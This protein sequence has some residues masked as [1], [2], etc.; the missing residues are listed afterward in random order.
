MKTPINA[1]SPPQI[2]ETAY[3]E[4][5]SR[6]NASLE[7]KV[8]PMEVVSPDISSCWRKNTSSLEALELANLLRALR[9]VAGHLGD[10]VGHI[11][12]AGMS[13]A[14]KHAI[15]IEPEMVMGRYPVPA[16]KVDLLVGLLVHEAMHRMEWSDHVWKKLEPAME[17][18]TPRAKVIFQK[19]VRT[20]ESIFMDLRS[21]YTVFGLYTRI[22][23]DKATCLD[24]SRFAADCPCVDT[25]MTMWRE[26][27]FDPCR[28]PDIKPDMLPE[29][30]S[31]FGELTK[32]T[33][34]LKAISQGAAGVTRRCE[35]R[36]G[37]YLD[38]WKKIESRIA[39]WKIIDK[40]LYWFSYLKSAGDEKKRTAG[41]NSGKNKKLPPVLAR[42]IET[43][44][45][46]DAVDMTPLIRSVAGYENE[47]VAPMSRWDFQSASHPVVDR[48]MIGRLRAVFSHY[49]ER[50]SLMSRGLASGRIDQRRLY[51][52]GVDGRCF[53][54]I[55]K[56]PNLDWSVGLL[57]DASGSMRGN[58]WQMVE[59]TIATIHKALSGYRNR[60]SAWA[61]F[62]VSGICM[63]SRLITK[64]QLF[65]VPPA[66]QTA[67]GQAII[68]SA[69]MM[70]ENVKHTLLIHITDGESNFGCDV[71]YGLEYCRQ[72]KIQL[73][74]LGCGYKDR[75][76]MEHQYGRS[77][78]FIDYFEQLPK[79][80]ETL[81]KWAF[82]YGGI[83]SFQAPSILTDSA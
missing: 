31:P 38:T 82:L 8:S 20:G 39:D 52:A 16:Q 27:A 72:R 71:S 56:I 7:I 75:P 48:K 62:E 19:L 83:R 25:L 53:T 78:Q 21:E 70:P 60:L 22:V 79:A 15:L 57:V 1:I 29:Q 32:M 67:S 13:T 6:E 64:N 59:N 69:S 50:N 73:I 46:G 66:G 34:D 4:C 43:C 12:Y 2:R 44:L 54:S 3:A 49:A 68:A 28:M 24:Q 42:D 77:I 11:E 51:R 74:T 18:M 41:L 65:S 40:Q 9:K 37:L 14:C 80:M 55:D 10:N 81:F 33:R 5:L 58:K 17:E 35:Q 26:S 36:A 47:T 45:S 61:Y 63:I 76:A 23:R 30:N